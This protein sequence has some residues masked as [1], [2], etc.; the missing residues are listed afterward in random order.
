MV[1]WKKRLFVFGMG[2]LFLI[3]CFN[4]KENEMIKNQIITD[5]EV[6]CNSTELCEIEAGSIDDGSDDNEKENTTGCYD[7]L[8]NVQITD[9][10]QECK[11]NETVDDNIS[12]EFDFAKIPEYSGE[13]YVIINGN[14]PHFTDEQ[15]STQAYEFYSE[16][17]ALGRCSMVYACIGKEIM[18]TVERGVIGAVKPSGW[19]IVKYDCVEGKYLYNR[20]HLIGYQLTGENSNINNLITGTRYMNTV[21]ML[22]FE[23]MVANYIVSTGNHVL[24]RVTP[25][26]FENNLLA[27]GVHMEAKSVEDNGAGVLFNVYVY[28]VQPGVTI[29]YSTGDSTIEEFVTETE[30]EYNKTTVQVAVSYVLNTNTKK[31]HKTTCSSV[32]TI[33]E[34]NRSD[35][36]GDRENLMKR[37]YSACKR[38]NP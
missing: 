15:L 28:N 38:C 22:Q 33:K 26:F 6:T 31:F 3:I 2:V 5:T 11:E 7:M 24:Y 4:G 36:T 21:G 16:L 30:S 18:P 32:Q 8:E 19:H 12:L 20:C 25:I 10:E 27:S 37:G 34:K 23:N 1:V 9:S 35:Y 13:P 17:D 29:D 14:V